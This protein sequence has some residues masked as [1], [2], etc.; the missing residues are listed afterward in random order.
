MYLVENFI[1]F[2]IYIKENFITV[3]K[4]VKIIFEM[5]TTLLTNFFYIKK[6][7]VEKIFSLLL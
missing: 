1:G 5:P 4:L 2:Q 7:T 6:V 3:F